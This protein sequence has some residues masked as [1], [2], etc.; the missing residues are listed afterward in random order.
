MLRRS[1]ADHDRTLAP[2]DLSVRGKEAAP[3]P[4]PDIA[5][6]RDDVA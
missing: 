5:L 4:L 1:A 6:I 2:A 3:H